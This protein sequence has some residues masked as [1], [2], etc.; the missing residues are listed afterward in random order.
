MS[1]A[2][3]VLL[4][5][6]IVFFNAVSAFCLSAAELAAIDIFA[7]MRCAVQGFYFSWRI[8]N[9]IRT[10]LA[11]AAENQHGLDDARWTWEQMANV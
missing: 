4:S 7:R 11:D 6:S 5:E 2:I 3:L 10:G 9:D 8:A 1:S